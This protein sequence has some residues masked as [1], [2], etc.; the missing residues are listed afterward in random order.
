MFPSGQQ[1]SPFPVHLLAEQMIHLEK[2][3]LVKELMC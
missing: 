2:L 1:G 3:T